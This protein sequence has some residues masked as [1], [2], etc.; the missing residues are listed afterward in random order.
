MIALLRGVARMCSGYQ[1]VSERKRVPEAVVGLGEVLANHAFRGMAVVAD[2]DGAILIGSSRRTARSSRGSWH[3]PRDR[4]SCTRRPWHTRTCNR[5]CPPRGRSGWPGRGTTATGTGV[6]ST[7]RGSMRGLHRHWLLTLPPGAPI[8]KARA[9]VRRTPR[10]PRAKSRGRGRPCPR[11]MTSAS[12]GPN[13]PTWRAIGGSPPVCAGSHPCR[14]RGSA[15]GR[16]HARGRHRQDRRAALRSEQ[17]PNLARRLVPVDLG[18]VAVHQ[19]RDVG[20][21]PRHPDGLPTV[22]GDVRDIAPSFSSIRA[23]T[24]WL[25]GLSSAT[26]TRRPGKG[27]A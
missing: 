11:V 19:N 9:S 22:D 23:A 3:R 20:P 27:D 10:V 7:R 25:T 13:G 18:H 5:R 15:R 1:P 16:P 24:R 4:W 2:G 14:R 12:A 26:S 17:L 21:L 6:P 8:G